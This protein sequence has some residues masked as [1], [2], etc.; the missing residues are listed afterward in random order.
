MTGPDGT[1][2]QGSRYAADRGVRFRPFRRFQYQSSRNSGRRRRYTSKGD[3]QVDASGEGGGANLKKEKEVR[4]D[5]KEAAPRR[6]PR[7][8]R[9][10][11][12]SAHT[13]EHDKP[14]VEKSG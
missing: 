8:I 10:S 9:R 7:R 3:K 12:G 11:T 13:D 4:V 14:V 1:C 5:G 2:V 6:R